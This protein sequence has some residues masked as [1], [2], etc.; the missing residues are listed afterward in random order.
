ML[1][2]VLGFVLHVFNRGCSGRCRCNRGPRGI[3]VIVVVVCTAII[4]TIVVVFVIVVIAVLVLVLAGSD[5]WSCDGGS[6]DRGCGFG[7]F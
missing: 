4:V 2:L 1:L 5:V 3:V 7:V 6:G